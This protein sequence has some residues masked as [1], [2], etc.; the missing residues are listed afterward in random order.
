MK[1]FKVDGTILL[2]TPS[3]LHSLDNQD[4]DALVNRENLYEFLE[5]YATTHVPIESTIDG[6]Q[7]EAPIGSQE[8]WAAGVTYLRSKE[9]RMDEAKDSGGA[10]FYA[11][12]YE[13]KRPELFFKSTAARCAGPDQEVLIR[14]DSQ[15][16]VPEP[17]LTLFAN[18]TGKI[19]GYTIGNDMSSRDIEGENP[20]YLPQAKC[21]QR[22]AAIGPCL[23]VTP[24]PIDADTQI[25]MSIERNKEIVFSGSISI[26]QM[27]RK[28]VELISYLFMEMDFPQGVY[29]MTG[30]CLV[31][32]NDF[33]LAVNDLVHISIDGI[34]SLRNRV[35]LKQ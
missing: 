4:W 5:A 12:V 10:D 19:V 15:W 14:R 24:K 35:A 26:N 23:L 2:Q 27:K 1:L 17:E 18:A 20:L 21:Y 9:A 28:H 11:K 16:N 22:S 6:K 33:T 31:P 29:L 25:H 32:P 13:A 30:T 8:I 7:L 34:G 3:A